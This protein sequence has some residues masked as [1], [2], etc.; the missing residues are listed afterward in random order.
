MISAY[1]KRILSH[2][3]ISHGHLVGLY[4]RF[5]R[6]TGYQW[7]MYLKNFGHLYAMGDN[8]CIQTNVSF[9][10]PQHV[11]LGNNVHLTGC[12]LFGH[13]GSISM[14]KQWRKIRLDRVGKID[15]G[16]NVFVGHQAIIMPGVTIGPNAIIGAGALVTRDVPP[17]SVVGGV[18]A[19]HICSLDA[20]IQRCVLETQALSW[21]DHPNLDLAY[22][23][24][25]AADLTNIRIK[26]FFENA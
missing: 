21:C 6:P 24:S 23:G 19:R 3:A 18:P 26:E 15:I 25:A 20:Y 7:A 12:T 13:D 2:L 5:C 11:R 16:D 17:N 22:V 1:L 10:D 8:C 9:T 14:I 4:R